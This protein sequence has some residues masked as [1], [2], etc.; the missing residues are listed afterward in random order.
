VR[1]ED[2]ERLVL[3]LEEQTDDR[4]S[5]TFVP[6]GFTKRESDILY[7]LIRGK[8]NREIALRLG[9]SPNTVRTRLEDIFPKLGVSTRTA[10]ALRAREAFFTDSGSPYTPSLVWPDGEA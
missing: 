8:T 4:Q 5:M 1:E 7:W 3:W 6:L 10:A 9:L 2:K